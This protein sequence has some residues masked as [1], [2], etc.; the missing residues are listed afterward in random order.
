MSAQ[1]YPAQSIDTYK[2]ADSDFDSD[3]VKKFRKLYAIGGTQLVFL[4]GQ[5]NT[6]TVLAADYSAI[7]NQAIYVTTIKSTTDC[8]T[9]YAST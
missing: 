3:I 5:G 1:I 9:L 2:E 8:T 7:N 4:D 6:V